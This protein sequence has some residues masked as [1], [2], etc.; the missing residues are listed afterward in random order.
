[1]TV[2]PEFIRQMQRNP[3]QWQTHS[4]GHLVGGQPLCD[5]VGHLI[6]ATPLPYGGDWTYRYELDNTYTVFARAPR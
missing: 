1:V 4:T 2:T 6:R 5:Y 3:G